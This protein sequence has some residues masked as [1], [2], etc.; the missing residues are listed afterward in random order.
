VQ[1]GAGE[2]A[3]GFSPPVVRIDA[4]TEVVWEW[5]GEGG[6]HNVETLDAPEAFSSGEPV[7][8]D[9]YTWSYTFE[10]PGTYFYSCLPHQAAGM[11]GAVIVDG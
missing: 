9:G 7:A 2:I 1:V 8:E 5:T 6:A 3:F 4:G 11:H 10:T